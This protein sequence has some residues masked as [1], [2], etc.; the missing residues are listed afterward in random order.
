[1]LYA[2]TRSVTASIARC[3]LTHLARE[4]IDVERAHA[5]HRAYQEAL[6]EAGCSIVH[7]LEDDDA[8]MPDSVFV[9]DIALVLD[10]LA[11][12]TRPGAESRRAETEHVAAALHGYR[13]ITKRI[14][15][16][17]TLDGGDVLVVGRDVFVGISGRTNA[18]GIEQLRA[19]LGRYNYRVRAVPVRGCLHLKSAVTRVGDRLLLI[20]RDWAPAEAFDG[21]ELLDVDPAEPAGANA[22][23]VG[24]RVIYPTA[25]P[26]TRERMEGRGVR[27]LAVEAGELAKAEGGVTCCSLVFTA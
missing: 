24:D 23:L 21:F 4:P 22:L 8:D 19:V 20:N 13:A 18:H 5:E 7:L 12:L 16:P 14:E 6:S 25:F 15:A 2:L 27:V 10:E 26:R 17:G 11:V 9:E 1:M 3:E